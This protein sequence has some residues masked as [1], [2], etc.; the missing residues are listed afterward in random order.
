[1]LMLYLMLNGKL[2]GPFPEDIAK[3]KSSAF[4]GKL[5]TEYEASQ[6]RRN[7]LAILREK[8]K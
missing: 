1:M 2:I 3:R 6:F 4:G 8:R 5:V 7:Q